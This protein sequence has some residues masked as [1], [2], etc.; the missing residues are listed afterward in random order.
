MPDD[1][2]R[3]VTAVGPQTEDQNLSK[4]YINSKLVPISVEI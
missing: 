2:D 3:K 4:L 1:S